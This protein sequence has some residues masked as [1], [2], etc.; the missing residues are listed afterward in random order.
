VTS[1]A[2]LVC[3][4]KDL[5]CVQSASGSAMGRY[6]DVDSGD[7]SQTELDAQSRRFCS[8]VGAA[9]GATLGEALPVSSVS[10]SLRCD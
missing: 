2:D 4:C 10:V 3:A 8:C 9:I 7:V 1:A 5:E 6:L